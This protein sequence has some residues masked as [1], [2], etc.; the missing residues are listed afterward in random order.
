MPDT[1]TIVA[2]RNLAHDPRPVAATRFSFAGGAT[3]PFV[4]DRSYSGTG[5]IFLTL[6]A[7]SS[8]TWAAAEDDDADL[9]AI[10]SGTIYAAIHASGPISSGVTAISRIRY[11]D[12]STTDSAPVTLNSASSAFDRFVFAGLTVNGAKTI[13]NIEIIIT[14]GAGSSR[15]L[16]VGGLD[17][18]RNQVIDAFIH[19]SGGANYSWEG[20]TNASPSN[21]AAYTIGPAL[22][23]GGQRYPSIRVYVVNRQNQ[24]L[25]EITDHFIDGNI[26]YD[27][28]AEQWKG[29]CSLVLDEPGLVQPLV[30]EYVRVTQRIESPDGSVEEG[31][32]GLFNVDAPTER[33]SEGHDQW[34]YEGKDMLSL[35]ATWNLPGVELAEEDGQGK[36]MASFVVTPNFSYATAIRQLL[37]DRAEF[38]QFQ[39]NF[40]GLTGTAEMGIAWEEGD[41]VLTMLTDIL[42]AA[43]WQK[44]WV[45]PEGIITSA[46]AGLDPRNVPP[47]LVLTTGEN[48]RVRWPFEVDPETSRVGNRVRVV[49]TKVRNEIVGYKNP[50]AYW[51]DHM[52]KKKKKKKKKKKGKKYGWVNEPILIDPPPEPRRANVTYHV[53]ATATNT[54]P[55]H[56]LSR[57]RLG[58]WIDLPT[59]TLPQVTDDDVAIAHAQQALIDASNIPVR[60]RLTTE[61]MVRGLHE[62]YE[63]DLNDAYGNPIPSGQG[64]YW[65]RGWTMQLGSPWEMVHNLTR[66]V[67]FDIASGV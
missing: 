56:P 2:G 45:T 36:L 58:R 44:P 49:S 38:A 27:L 25:R 48:S 31:S 14:N 1:V 65:C 19:G 57:Q 30:D 34:S 11:T 5:S 15:T 18:R 41:S 63:L 20:A 26:N 39:Y 28:D 51:Q 21:R 8:A 23:S 17:I 67:G 4:T 43:G 59:V 32:V 60:V 66:L 61:V 22:G 52:V 47:A 53:D 9:A 42:V 55:S 10:T 7:G 3:G 54:D 50:D 33:W 37:V 35:L 16:Y 29:S 62:V 40:P 46:P 24:A 64:R 13:R 12:G 6:P